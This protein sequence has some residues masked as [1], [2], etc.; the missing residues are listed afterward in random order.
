MDAK[1]AQ[2]R[3]S[4]APPFAF[5]LVDMPRAGFLFCYV[6]DLDEYTTKLRSCE[7]TIRTLPCGRRGELRAQ[8]WSLQRCCFAQDGKE[9]YK[10]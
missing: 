2:K 8:N 10:D 3:L 7:Q 4:S 6:G 1:R 5:W 9:M